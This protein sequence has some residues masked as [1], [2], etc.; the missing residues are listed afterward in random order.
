M[1]HILLW[2]TLLGLKRPQSLSAFLSPLLDELL[3]LE[4][5]IKAFNATPVIFFTLI[6]RCVLDQLE[7]KGQQMFLDTP[8]QNEYQ[9]CNKSRLQGTYLPILSKMMYPGLQRFLSSECLLNTSTD[10]QKFPLS[11][12]GTH[13]PPEG[14]TQPTQHA[15]G[16][17]YARVRE[18][19]PDATLKKTAKSTGVKG[20]HEVIL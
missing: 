6:A 4:E 14:R 17:G 8:A 10:N 15:F 19:S 18:N 12:K 11:A 1:C 16:M 5:G 2:A 3:V 13:L 9:R 20:R 7:Y